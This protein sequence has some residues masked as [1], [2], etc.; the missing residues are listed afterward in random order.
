VK[1]P[2]LD[3]KAQIDPIRKEIEEAISRVIDSG[4]FVL[5]KEIEEFERDIC[6]YTGAKYAIGVSNGTD[7]ISL[8]LEALEIDK[9][10]KVICPAFTYFATAGA[11][12]HAGAEPVF[13]DI[14]PKTYCISSES[15]KV[16]LQRT[17]NN[18]L[19][20]VKAIIPVHLYGQTVDMDKIMDIAKERNL[21]V[22]EDTAQAFGSTYKD[23]KAGTIG[24]CG[25][26]SFFPA[27]NLGAF[28]DAGMIITNKEDAA[29][30]LK[31]LRN[32]GSDPK[33]K[34][35]HI[36]NG[37]NNRLD[38]I[39]AAV[40]RIKLKHL[41]KWNKKRADNAAYYNESLKGTGL[42]IPQLQDGS[43]H[44]YHQYILRAKNNAD[45]ER[46]LAHLNKKGIDSRVYYPIP[47]HLQPSFEYLGY[48]KGDFPESEKAA[49]E[50]FAIP[51]YP[52][53]TKEQMDYIIAAI[54]ER[55]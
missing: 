10:D 36:L 17:M 21:K 33:V 40:L 26:I 37:H 53:L 51:V 20:T 19:R 52:E 25:S 35:R 9:G 54:K 38:T 47:L 1:I 32:Q 42:L 44:I 8:A 29:K 46:I 22:V 28:G 55:L 7:A 4:A 39:Q 34:Y 16:F 13:V 31:S 23:K 24:D 45:R 11:I 30:K 5:G 41:D 48:K 14:D 12:I 18:E 2:L 3:M 49:L 27:K 6:S 50:T 15:I 43:T